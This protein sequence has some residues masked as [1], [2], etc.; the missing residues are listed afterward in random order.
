[1]GH[2]AQAVFSSFPPYSV[3]M[4]D[5]IISEWDV[6]CYN[7]NRWMSVSKIKWF[8]MFL[9]QFCQL[10]LVRLKILSV[11]LNSDEARPKSQGLAGKHVPAPSKKKKLYILI[12]LFYHINILQKIFFSCI[13]LW[14]PVPA[15]L[16]PSRSIGMLMDRFLQYYYRLPWAQTEPALIQTCSLASHKREGS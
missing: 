11:P 8:G 4:N 7:H 5:I 14:V 2:H 12:K 3:L 9:W 6:G 13:L 10:F 15:E 1:M 16:L